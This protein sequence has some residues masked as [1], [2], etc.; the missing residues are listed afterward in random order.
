MNKGYHEGLAVGEQDAL[1]I[2]T[3]DG[4]FDSLAVLCGEG[5]RIGERIAKVKAVR[6]S[7]EDAEATQSRRWL[8]YAD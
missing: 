2:A 8:T 7:N 1:L 4:G 5:L 3:V 6:E